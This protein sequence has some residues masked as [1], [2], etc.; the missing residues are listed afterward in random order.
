MYLPYKD[1]IEIGPYKINLLVMAKKDNSGNFAGV[2]TF[3]SIIKGAENLVTELSQSATDFKISAIIK[4]LNMIKKEWAL[5]N[6]QLG[7]FINLPES[8][9]ILWT[10][11]DSKELGKSVTDINQILHFIAIYKDLSRLYPKVID[12]K[13]WLL[14]INPKL[15][16][17]TPLELITDSESGLKNIRRFLKEQKK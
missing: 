10:T 6:T 5:S 17:K 3:W 7:K 4:M 12:Q 14:T 11:A 15:S 9:I 2:T 16:N 8:T 13:R 1:I